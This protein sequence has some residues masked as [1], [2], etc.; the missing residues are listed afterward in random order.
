[1]TALLRLPGSADHVASLVQ[2][3]VRNPQTLAFLD[4]LGLPYNLDHAAAGAGDHEGGWA[5]APA[6]ALAGELGC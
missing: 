6:Y 2:H 5:G 3:A 1:M 4:M